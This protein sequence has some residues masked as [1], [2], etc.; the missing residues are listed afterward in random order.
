MKSNCFFWTIGYKMKNPNSRI[1]AEFDKT[2]GFY[3]FYIIHNEYEFHCEQK[4]R[5]DKWSLF[6]EY[7]IYKIK[8]KNGKVHQ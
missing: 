4:N 6:F 2:L 5:K 7:K 1:K 3:H 8:I